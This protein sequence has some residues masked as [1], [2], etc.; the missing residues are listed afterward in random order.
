MNLETLR[1]TLFAELQKLNDGDL[2]NKETLR[3]AIDHAQ[4]VTNVADT[5]LNS[6][7]IEL[8]YCKMM[9]RNTPLS[10]FVPRDLHEEEIQRAAAKAIAARRAWVADNPDKVRALSSSNGLADMEKTA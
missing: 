2:S 4:A 9:Q 5:I 10:G 1:T 3:G 6:C 7:R 8:D